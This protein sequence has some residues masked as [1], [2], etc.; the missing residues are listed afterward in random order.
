MQLA[1]FFFIGSAILD[2]VLLVRWVSTVPNICREALTS[3]RLDLGFLFLLPPIFRLIFLGSLAV[4]AFGFF[5]RQRWALILYYC[6]FPLRLVFL[7]LSFGFLLLLLRPFAPLS[8]SH[9]KITI[10][11]LIA[12]EV[13]R[14]IVSVYFHR[15][16]VTRGLQ[17]T[18]A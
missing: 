3:W 14:L 18:V 13:A 5:Q 17:A 11:R 10:F 4:S 2:A 15:S 7:Y 16:L 8:P 9:Y 6:Q 12:L 1:K